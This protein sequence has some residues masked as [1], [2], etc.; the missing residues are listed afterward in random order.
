MFPIIKHLDELKEKVSH[1]PEI[2]FMEHDNGLTTVCYMI[3]NNDTFFGED[4]EWSRECRGITFHKDGSIA[5]RPMHKFFNINENE[6]TQRHKIDFSKVVRKM[7]KLDGSLISAC[8]IDGEVKLK[9]K[10]SFNSSV[11][12][13]ANQFIKYKE[14]YHEFCRHLDNLGYSP[15]FEFTSHKARIVINHKEEKLTLLHIRSK[16]TGKYLPTQDLRFISAMFLIP[17]VDEY[18]H[19][20]SWFEDQIENSEGIEGFVFQFEDGSMVKYKTKWYLNLHGLVTFKSERDIA[21]MILTE[22]IDDYKSYLYSVEDIELLQKISEIEQI[23]TTD[24][25]QIEEEV[26]KNVN[27]NKHLSRK[28]FAI[29][30]KDHKFFSLIINMYLDNEVNIKEFYYKNFFKDKFSILQV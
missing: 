7:D 17:L 10:K 15:D 20:W 14:N 18:S 8:V 13:L 5:C 12:I 25:V 24:L 21:E 4:K 2:R 30:F 6:E 22:N 23:I 27:E 1:K 16:S 19:D 3:S 28:D 26:E 9:S 11:A 29:K